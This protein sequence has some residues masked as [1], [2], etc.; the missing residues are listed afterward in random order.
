MAQHIFDNPVAG[1]TSTRNAFNL[2]VCE[3]NTSR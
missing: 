2:T 3:H 1:G